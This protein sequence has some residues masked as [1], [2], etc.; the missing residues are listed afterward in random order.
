LS[1]LFPSSS[2]D[3]GQRLDAALLLT[4]SS[5]PLRP[6]SHKR[7]PDSCALKARPLRRLASSLKLLS[8][9]ITAWQE[10]VTFM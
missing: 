7:N 2:I 6:R 8:K 10:A 3:S 1:A 9:E 4:S 5:S